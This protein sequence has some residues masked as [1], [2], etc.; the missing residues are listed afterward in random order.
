[1]TSPSYS[2]GTGEEHQGRRQST[3]Q[4]TVVGEGRGEH[5]GLQASVL[6]EGGEHGMLTAR[7]RRMM[8]HSHAA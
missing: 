8:H 7:D 3:S 5:G 6:R 1:M 2:R 4:G